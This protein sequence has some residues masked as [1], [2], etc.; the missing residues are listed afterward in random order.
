[1]YEIV[2]GVLV[3]I[4]SIAV[5]AATLFTKSDGKGL[6]GLIGAGGAVNADNKRKAS[7]MDTML[8]RI[9]CVSAFVCGLGVI[10]LGFFAAHF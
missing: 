2:L 5:T 7:A 9:I 4:A 6:A 10:G 1:M 3:I 8:T